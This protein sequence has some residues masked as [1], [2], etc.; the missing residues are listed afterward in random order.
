MNRTDRLLGLILFLQ[1]R[2]YATAADMAAHFG[3]SL[4]TIYRD[5]KALAEAGVPVLAEAG[6]GYSLM[7][8]Y[9]LPPVNFTE[10]EAMA[11][12]TGAMLLERAAAPTLSAYME[13]ALQKVRTVLP[14]ARREDLL[15]LGRAM[16]ATA[17]ASDPESAPGA[18]LALIQKALTRRQPLRFD[19]RGHG[20]PHAAPREVEPLGLLRYLGRWHLIAWC[21]L[22]GALRDFRTDRMHRPVMLDEHF[23]PREDFD[24][25]AYVREHMPR[26]ELRATVR[27][28][29]D[30]A[31]RVWREWWMG[32]ADAPGDH[33]N[34]AQ[35]CAQY[36][37]RDSAPDEDAGGTAPRASVAENGDGA[38]SG[39]TRHAPSSV[40]L[41]LSAVDWDHLAHWLLSFGPLATVL[42]PPHLRTLLAERAEAAAHHHRQEPGGS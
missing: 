30:A 37:A 6:V 36:S 35:D 21:R 17:L 40:T 18:D 20:K 19:Y 38:H 39:H 2:R 33:P 34:G 13:S 8:G 5:M 3:L 22:R 15:R 14:P 24:P 4:R 32:V 10:D 25:G 41:T 11:L 31:D 27:F 28:H 42:D 12:T 23:A 1:S 7:R 9:L 16:D 29:P 26:P